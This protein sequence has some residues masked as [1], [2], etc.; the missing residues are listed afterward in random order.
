M[1]FSGLNEC[2]FVHNA[3]L[4]IIHYTVGTEPTLVGQLGRSPEM[5]STAD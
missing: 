4:Y 1:L 5:C 2:N 3:D